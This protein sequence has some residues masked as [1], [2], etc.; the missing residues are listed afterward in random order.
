MIFDPKN[1]T[2][3]F[4]SYDE[5]NSEENY[6]HL[7]KLYPKAKRVHGIKGS[8]TAHKACAELSETK[9]VIIIDG[10]NHVRDDFFSTLIELD[11]D[12]DNVISFA[13]YNIINGT[14]YGNGGIKCWDI[15]SLKNMRT[16]ENS[17]GL[18]LTIDFDYHT[19]LEL[20]TVASDLHINSS[21]LQAWRAGFREVFKLSLDEQMDWRNYD[22]VYR[23][24]HIGIDV[25][26]GLYAIHGSR[27][28][29]HLLKVTEYNQIENVRDFDFLNDLF[30][31]LDVENYSHIGLIEKS[32]K[33]GQS[34]KSHTHD[35][36]ISDVLLPCDSKKYRERIF[37]PVR[38][39]ET[40]LINK[41]TTTYDI[42]FIHN[43]EDFAQENYIKLRDRFPNTKLLSGYVGIHNAHIVASKMATTD[44][45]WVVDSDAII[46]SDFDFSYVVDF[47][48]QPT[49]HVFRA[50]NPVNNL[51]YGH[52]AVKL[53]PRIAT[54]QM[55]TKAVDMTTSIS[56]LYKKVDIVSN[57]H[58]FNTSAYNAWRTA[59]RECVKLSSN[60]ID[61]QK[62]SESLERLYI[63]CSVNNNAEYG[64]ITIKGALMGK[65]FGEKY[66]QD[67]N[68]LALINDYAWLKKK[69]DES[70]VY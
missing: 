31:K 15:D 1:Y 16:H 59:F 62:S 21:P 20:N 42:V 69:Y 61:R 55:N 32:N 26:N 13:G 57:I 9:R 66:K 5:P 27:Y 60:I 56:K 48:L 65:V 68:A 50:I 46:A 44:Y 45:F 28:A 67:T 25:T 40:F 19:Y 23:W 17:N 12:D 34:I 18:Q 53:L 63:W 10:D 47:Y 51:K 33:L 38:S 2:V 37:N 11:C 64:D 43:Y 49:T 4:L 7:L 6:Q 52:G 54:M 70:I 22:R 24:M 39:P 3:I 58:K 29:Y 8:D 35:D 41:K 36:R 30:K 14:S